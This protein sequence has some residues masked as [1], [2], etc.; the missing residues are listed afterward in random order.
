MLHF[1]HLTKLGGDTDF[2]FLQTLAGIAAAE[3]VVIAVVLMSASAEPPRRN[4]K[5]KSKAA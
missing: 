1:F 3:I 2:T 5:K 4:G